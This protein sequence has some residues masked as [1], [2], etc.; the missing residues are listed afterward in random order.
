[1][2]DSVVYI[3]KSKQRKEGVRPTR[4]LLD[5]D[6]KMELDNM[7]KKTRGRKERRF[8][9]LPAGIKRR[10]KLNMGVG[11]GHESLNTSRY[12][13]NFCW[14]LDGEI[15]HCCSTTTYT[16][17]FKSPYTGNCVR[18]VT[19]THTHVISIQLGRARKLEQSFLLALAATSRITLA[20]LDMFLS[21]SALLSLSLDIRSFRVARH[22]TTASGWIDTGS[23]REDYY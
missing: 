17:T 6:V 2:H 4:A 14:N 3:N 20:R 5:S 21:L 23:G 1:M 16:F 8:P 9:I 19:H 13:C 10:W 12:P 22:A 11:K 7:G 18:V 15:Q